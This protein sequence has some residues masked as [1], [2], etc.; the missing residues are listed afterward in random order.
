MVLLFFNC[1]ANDKIL[2][3]TELKAFADDKSDVS[4]MMIFVYD[5][6]ENIVGEKAQFLLFPKCFQKALVRV[7]KIRDCV[8][9]C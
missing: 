6:V 7:V 1:L 4:K 2:H 9:K 3:R 5:W 8:V